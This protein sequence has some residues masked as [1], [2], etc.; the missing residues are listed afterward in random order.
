MVIQ[1]CTLIVNAEIP[2]IQVCNLIVNAYHLKT[3]QRCNSHDLSQLIP[4]D[5]YFTAEPEEPM[6]D[7]FNADVNANDVITLTCRGKVGQ[8]ITGENVAE[9]DIQIQYSVRKLLTIVY[10]FW[11]D[12]IA[13]LISSYITIV[14]LT[15]SV[16]YPLNVETLN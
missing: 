16:F 1:V 4:F 11:G 2:V 13:L 8:N 7:T 15:V 5:L 3:Y 9:I 12:I 6:L 10:A 14:M